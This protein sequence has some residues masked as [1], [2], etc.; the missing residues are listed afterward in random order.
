MNITLFGNDRTIES[1]D[2]IAGIVEDIKIWAEAKQKTALMDAYSF[3]LCHADNVSDPNA[4]C[5]GIANNFLETEDVIA[6]FIL[7][8][9]KETI[10]ISARSTDELDVQSFMEQLGGSGDANTA[11]A[12]LTDCT[13]EDGLRKLVE[14]LPEKRKEGDTD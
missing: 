4:I 12:Q 3:S 2:D 9:C 14:I 7:M 13:L 10:Y 6:S 11:S 5:S 8:E 1:E